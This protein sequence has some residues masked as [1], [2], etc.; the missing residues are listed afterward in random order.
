MLYDPNTLVT[1]SVSVPGLFNT[2]YGYDTKGRMTSI[3]TNTRGIDFTYNEQG[4][5][6]SISDPGGDTTTYTHDATGR[7]TGS[8]VRMEVI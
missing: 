5:L 2:S 1:E 6:E 7:T 3:D 8:A 4:F